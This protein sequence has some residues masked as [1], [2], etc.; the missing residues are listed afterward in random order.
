ML[1]SRE[2]SLTPVPGDPNPEDPE[3]RNPDTGNP[4]DGDPG[5][6]DP[7]DGDP[8]DNNPGNNNNDDDDADPDNP[9][10][11]PS[12]DVGQNLADAISMLANN[13]RAPKAQDRR[14]RIREPDTFDGSD[15]KKL[16]SFLVQCSLNFRDRPEAF[17]NDTAKVNYALSYLKG[18]ALDWFEPTLLGLPDDPDRPEWVG[19]Y[20]EFVSILETNFGPYDPEGEAE[21]DLENLRMRDNQHITKYMVEFNRLA[22]RVSWGDA[23]LRRRYYDGLP[24]RIKDRI[25]D[26]GKPSSLARMR[27]LTQAIDARYWERRSEVSREHTQSTHKSDKAPEKKPGTQH[28]DKKSGSG[29]PKAS[30]SGS[31]P[32]RRSTEPPT[33]GKDGKLTQQERQRRFDN[34]L[35]LYCGRTGHMASDCPNRVPAATKAKGRAAKTSATKPEA[36]SEAKSAPE[37]PKN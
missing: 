3:P 23:A 26:V 37:Q 30:S 2:S 13:L 36:K 14:T 7:G 1:R 4:G 35:C 28:T 24:P 6:G 32:P 19:D 8:G 17:A 34:N 16:Q 31:N 5:D 22:A 25:A 18:T 27:I 12:P 10:R 29:P 9:P 15:P 21:A 33:K 11:Q 20:M